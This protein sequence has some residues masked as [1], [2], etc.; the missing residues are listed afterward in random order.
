[1]LKRSLAATL[2]AAAATGAQAGNL[3]PDMDIHVAPYTG[4]VVAVEKATGQHDI[5]SCDEFVQNVAQ[6]VPYFAGFAGIAKVTGQDMAE[7]RQ[8]APAIKQIGD[9]VEGCTNSRYAPDKEA[10][11]LIRSSIEIFEN[12]LK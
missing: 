11:D 3:L 1:M 6:L 4:Y 12:T 2:M 10:S 7:F 5:M 9:A 8:V